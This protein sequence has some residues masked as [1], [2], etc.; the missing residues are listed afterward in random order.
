MDQDA[1]MT[2]DLLKTTDACR[3]VRE[4]SQERRSGCTWRIFV[5]TRKAGVQ[6]WHRLK[7]ISPDLSLKRVSIEAV[8]AGGTRIGAFERITPGNRFTAHAFLGLPVASLRIRLD[9]GSLSGVPPIATLRRIALIQYVW[10][11]L[12]RGSARQPLVFLRYFFEPPGPF[13]ITPGF[14]QPSAFSD[15]NAVYQWWIAKREGP[16]YE[17]LLKPVSV[18]ITERPSIAILMTVCDPQPIAVRKAIDSVQRQTSDN[19]QLCIADDASTTPEVIQVL[20]NAAQSD[21]RIQLRLLSRRGGISAASNTAF[22]LVSSPFVARLDQDGTL[23]RCAVDILSRYLSHGNH[24]RLAYSD[25]DRIGPSGERFEPFFK[26]DFSREL[27]YSSNYLNHLTVYDS[28]TIR[29]IGGWGSEFDGAQDYDLNLRIVEVIDEKQIGHVPMILYHQ[30]AVPVSAS[31]GTAVEAGRR[32]VSEHLARRSVSA[33]V[34]IVADAMHRVRY[35]LANPEPMVSIIIPFRDD[36]DVLQ[37]CM[38]SI[39]EKTSYRN[40]E[41][42]LVDNG[43]IEPSTLSLLRSYQKDP[44]VHILPQPGAFNYSAL[45]NRAVEYSHGD[46]LCL[47]NND[48]IVITPDWLE[49]MVGYASQPGVGCV[50]AK[51]YYPSGAIQHAGVVLGLSGLADHAF[52]NRPG[53]DPGYFGRLQIASNYSAVTGACLVVSRAVYLEAGG[54]D[55]RDLQVAFNDVDFCIKVKSRGYRNVMTPFAELFHHESSSRGLDRTLRFT[56]EVQVMKQRYGALLD[57]DPCYS[58]HLTRTK[59]DFSLRED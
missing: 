52:R 26:P 5:A 14:P 27:L 59:D 31:D 56:R 13:I 7:I 42:V 49:D 48:T 47:L 36:A 35:E 38:S 50:G 6:G 45:N 8:D 22:E 39:L 58:P 51:L 41:L 24:M 12:R 11:S 53:D 33:Q 23:A 10:R 28:E 29:R 34:H 30:R 2:I 44:R 21:K 1:L 3:H 40:Y 4:L 17:R 32:A 46:Y 16:A 20:A 43:S 37:Q 18:S 25:E 9:T 19:W 15:P 54:L 55:E 57:S